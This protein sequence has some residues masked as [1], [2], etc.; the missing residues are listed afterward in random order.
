MHKL[1]L[2]L[3]VISL[4]ALASCETLK[5]VDLTKFN[6]S[7]ALTTD[8]IIAGLKEAL[9]AGSDNA[10]KELS[11][12]GG[13][14]QN[15]SYRIGMPKALSEVTDTM[16]TI[17]LGSM[18]ADFENKMN[19]AAEQATAS[20]GPVFMDAITQMKFSD[21]KK[22]L[23]GSDTA[24][25]DYLRKTTYPKLMEL[26]KPIIEKNM[27]E[28]G[29]VQLYNNLMSKYDAIPF[30]SKP[31]FSLED[32]VTDKALDSMFTLLAVEEKKIR[33]NPAARTTELLK[34]VFGK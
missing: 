1:L 32:Y 19:K 30:K 15:D 16:K 20:A 2:S 8:K 28:V 24:A 10:V 29:A 7:G 25:T 23:D 34:E 3:S 31:K 18:V 17:G 11:K 22:I 12:Q 21:A 4:L 14:S 27:K 5:M 13:F 6:T 33:Q 9:N 26:Y